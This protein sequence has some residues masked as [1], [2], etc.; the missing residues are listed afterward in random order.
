MHVFGVDVVALLLLPA[1]WSPPLVLI[2][3]TV[4]VLVNLELLSFGIPI[5]LVR[6]G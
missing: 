5:W 2:G 1:K 4:F 3:L 6:L